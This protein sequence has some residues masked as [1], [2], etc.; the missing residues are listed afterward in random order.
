[1]CQG[2]LEEFS[3]GRR[4]AGSTPEAASSANVG[5]LIAGG[6]DAAIAQLA[7][8]ETFYSRMLAA[9]ARG[10]DRP[11]ASDAR[12][13][14]EL[15]RALRAKRSRIRGA[16]VARDA[17]L[18]AELGEA[19]L[20]FVE[21]RAMEAA[22]GF[23][24]LQTEEPL[25]RGVADW[26]LDRLL[27]DA[28]EAAA[29]AEEGART[30]E[31]A[32]EAFDGDNPAP[33]PTDERWARQA[34]S[35][36]ARLAQRMF[37][38]EPLRGDDLFAL[39]TFATGAPRA[40]G[41]TDLPARREDLAAWL[42]ASCLSAEMRGDVDAAV[43][44]IAI[45][46]VLLGTPD[47]EKLPAL[48]SVRARLLEQRGRDALEKAPESARA[49]LRAAASLLLGLAHGD[50]AARGNGAA[51][52]SQ[53]AELLELA[54]DYERAAVVL[55][56]SRARSGSDLLR[57]ARARIVLEQ[58]GD[59]IA[60]LDA[61]LDAAEDGARSEA[62]AGQIPATDD[63]VSAEARLWRAFARIELD[64]REASTRSHPP[65]PAAQPQ[66]EVDRL[67]DDDILYLLERLSFPSEICLA[68]RHVRALVLLGRVGA[69][70]MPSGQPAVTLRDE[71]LRKEAAARLESAQACLEMALTFPDLDRAW[72]IA[73]LEKVALVAEWRGR[74]DDAYRALDRL[75][76]IPEDDFPRA[77]ASRF[78]LLWR[79]GASRGVAA[80]DAAAF[81]R[82]DMALLAGHPERALQD[83]ERALRRDGRSVL[84]PWA[85]WQRSLILE[86]SGATGLARGERELARASLDGM[87]APRGSDARSVELLARWRAAMGAAV[88]E[89]RP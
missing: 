32:A 55:A 58:Y 49:D 69:A 31:L 36:A 53:A 17:R 88:R 76:E 1:M 48:A 74:F 19:L 13:G 18:E 2:T 5:P 42:G 59:A 46:E 45:L 14:R 4:A 67:V 57:L 6:F 56:S 70:V 85:H 27:A 50:A 3:A 29:A 10:V 9:T 63:P 82:A 78:R 12:D 89:A 8:A 51:R 83:Y 61:W 37:A 16:P 44:V 75:A 39:R 15:A 23:A 43:D 72:E 33:A 20:S 30:A 60:L 73:L 77:S 54:G 22:R 81:R 86:T 38:A 34:G 7:A 11:G 52:V 84:V 41:A 25:P 80:A 87:A 71:A 21:G 26:P 24:A 66:A 35:L 47:A 62:D 65:A 28:R 79:A 40:S 64:A 68:A